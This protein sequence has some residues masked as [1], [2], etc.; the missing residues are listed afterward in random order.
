MAF[1]LLVGC[2]GTADSLESGANGGGD[3]SANGGGSG[4]GGGVGSGDFGGAVDPATGLPVGTTCSD[5]ARS[6]MGLGGIELKSSRMEGQA[7]IDRA[8]TKSYDVLLGEYPRVLNANPPSMATLGPTL[9]QPPA[10][11]YAEPKAS[12][13]GLN[14][15]LAAAFEG[16]LAYTAKEAQFVANPTA[17]NAAAACSSMARKF[18]SRN[19]SESDVQGCVDV[20]MT[21]AAKETTNR[22][23]A[24]AC[25]SL[26]TST[27]F[28][29]Y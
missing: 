20:V 26:L 14:S 12:A 17:E 24:Y 6:Y 16:C 13:V 21:D 11:W 15:S 3:P 9:G 27:Q 2:S 8:R 10:H 29:A 23:W 25:A 4:T 19:A 5:R 7:G 22:R 1:S 18:W 28:L